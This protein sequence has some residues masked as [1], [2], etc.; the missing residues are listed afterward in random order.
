MYRIRRGKITQIV[1]SDPQRT[2]SYSPLSSPVDIHDGDVIVG[3]CV[4]GNDGDRA[5]QFG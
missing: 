5:I 4:Y 3:Q 1:K 2:R